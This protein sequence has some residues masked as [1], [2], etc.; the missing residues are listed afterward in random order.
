VRALK[1]GNPVEIYPVWDDEFL[2]NVRVDEEYF[3]EFF[4]E[5]GTLKGDYYI[6]APKPASA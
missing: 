4:P 2:K 1:D 5:R 6:I 3:E